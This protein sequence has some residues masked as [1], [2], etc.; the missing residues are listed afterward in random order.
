MASNKAFNLGLNIRISAYRIP[1]LL[2]PTV[3]IDWDFIT[4]T[5]LYSVI[6]KSNDNC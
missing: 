1:S 5:L 2:I 6:M 4:S 3:I